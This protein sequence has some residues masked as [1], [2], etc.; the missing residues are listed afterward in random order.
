MRFRCHRYD[1]H[2]ARPADN[3]RLQAAATA[4]RQALQAVNVAMNCREIKSPRVKSM[5][6]KKST[7]L[8]SRIDKLDQ[9]QRAATFAASASTAGAPPPPPPPPEEVDEPA[10]RVDRAD[11][12]PYTRAE[13]LEQYGGAAEW[14]RAPA[15]TRVDAADGN[16]YTRREFIDAYGGTAEWVAAAAGVSPASSVASAAGSLG[17]STSPTPATPP[18]PQFGSASPPPSSPPAAPAA[19][20][21]GSPAATPP[22]QRI[23]GD[24][25]YA[26]EAQIRGALSA[27]P[28]FHAIQGHAAAMDSLC[29]K[30]RP[31]IFAAGAVVISKGGVD[32][33][34]Y[35]VVAGGADI[36][37]ELGAAPVA[38]LGPG[39]YF[40]EGALV[41]AEPR[42][43]FVVAA[44]ELRLL[45]L[46]R[47]DVLAVLKA[48]PDAEQMY[49]AKAQAA[50]VQ[51]RRQQESG[52][53]IFHAAMDALKVAAKT[54]R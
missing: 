39:R 41:T 50:V 4:H 10:R 3:G 42:T 24:T 18:Q 44:T 32:T 22:Q 31:V 45:V 11:G 29:S 28:I 5:L 21:S 12:N 20:G 1:A 26:T 25:A 54:V 51:A 43:A 7:A 19:A 33:E 14:D 52:N 35:F 9:A 36:H 27:V 8:A 49:K 17:A 6:N 53:S 48:H 23:T 30:F 16:A 46:T 15:E 34:M 38:R 2:E 13:F 40:G 37:V 47:A